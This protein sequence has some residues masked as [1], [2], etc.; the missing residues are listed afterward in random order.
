MTGAVGERRRRAGRRRRR[1]CSRAACLGALDVGLV[2][3]VDA[4][5]PAGDGGGVLPQQQL[6]AQRGVDAERPTRTL[7]RTSSNSAR[8]GRSVT[9]HLVGRA[10]GEVRARRATSTTTGRMPLPS[11]PVDS[12]ISCSAQ[13]PKP[14]Y[15]GARRRPAPACRRRPGWPRPSRAP[16][17]RPGLS[18]ESASRSG[19]IASASSSSA[20]DVGAGQPARHQAEGGQRG[21]A[22]ADVGSARK[23]R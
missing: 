5:D 20:A 8:R 7:V 1:A 3:R 14:A 18:T 23:T 9:E 10:R 22:A 19:R 16:S 15:A 17:R 11:L 4:D 13:S 6:R 21:V 12:A 2:E